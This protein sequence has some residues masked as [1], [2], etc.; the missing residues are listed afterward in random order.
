MISV[1]ILDED[2]TLAGFTK[3]NPASAIPEKTQ[4]EFISQIEKTN[5]T[6]PI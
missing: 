1:R 6:C 4:A 2:A 5:K 3:E